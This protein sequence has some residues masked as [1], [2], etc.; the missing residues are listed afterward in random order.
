MRFIVLMMVFALTACGFSPLYM[1][2]DGKTTALTETIVIRPIADYGGYQME[3]DLS[4]LLNPT[5]ANV[6]K[7]YELFV[8]I[9]APTFSEQNIQDDNFSSRERMH[10]T[11]KYRLVNLQSGESVINATTS[12]T[13]AYNIAIEPYATYTAKQKVKENLIKMLS[14]RIATHVISFVKKTEGAREG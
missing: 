9:E 2:N 4:A 12:A 13:G 10:L 7:K 6:P 3:N 5:G 1:T 8:T 14:H 11:A